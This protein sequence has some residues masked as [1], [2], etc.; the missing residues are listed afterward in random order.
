MPSGDE[1]LPGGEGKLDVTI[2]SG[3][4]RQSLRQNVTLRTNDP[5]NGSITLLVTARVLVD[6]EAE[7]NL[8]RF[9][10]PRSP[11]AS[12]ALKNYTDAPVQ[13]SEIHSSSPYIDLSVSA[14][15][16]PPHGQVTVT[17]QVRPEAPKGILSGWLRLRTDLNTI[18]QLQIRLW[19]HLP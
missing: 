13:L 5:V 18:P 3:Y 16:I 1:I 8:L 7:P 10:L 11:S 12:L 14:L 6:L 15:T 19:G 17:A 9:D 2:R 4:R